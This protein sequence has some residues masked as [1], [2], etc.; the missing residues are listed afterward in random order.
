MIGSAL[1]LIT[2]FL[3]K[4][5]SDIAIFQSEL[6]GDN[7][8]S[9]RILGK[10]QEKKDVQSKLTPQDEYDHSSIHILDNVGFEV[11]VLASP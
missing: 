7:K 2:L 6:M 4:F 9:L 10:L 1:L 8:F 3:L 11:V 5:P